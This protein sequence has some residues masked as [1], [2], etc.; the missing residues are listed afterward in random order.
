MASLTVPS[1]YQP[2]VD[3]LEGKNALEGLVA[4]QQA[5]RFAQELSENLGQKAYAPGKWTL[6][7]LI[8]HILDSERVFAYRAMCIARGEKNDLPGF[9]QDAYVAESGANGRQLSDLV[10]ELGQLRAVNIS[11]FRSFT[12]EALSRKGLANG[13]EISVEVIGRIMAGHAMHH[14]GV[15]VKRYI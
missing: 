4:D 1:Y 13:V 6:N 9:D 7:E 10:K 5:W 14:R 8:A 11:L 3:L 12:Q 15:I 2:F